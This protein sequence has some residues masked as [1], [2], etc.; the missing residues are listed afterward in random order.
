MT[1]ISG[2]AGNGKSLPV[3]A[4]LRL[5]APHNSYRIAF[6]ARPTAR[7]IREGNRWRIDQHTTPISTSTDATNFTQVTAGNWASGRASKAAGWPARNVGFVRIRVNAATGGYVTIGGVRIGGRTDEPALVSTTLPGD[8]PVYRLVA[9][10]SGKVADV[11]GGPPPTTPT[12]TDVLQWPW[13]NK[14][15]Q[16]W[17]FPRTDDCYHEIKGVGSGKLMEVAGLSRADGG[18][19]GI[20]SAPAPPSS[21]GPSPPPVTAP[22]SSSTATAGPASPSTRAAPPTEPMSSNS[23]TR[24]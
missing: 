17:T 16:K 21:T 7:D 15:N 6:R 4:S 12:N 13:L 11:K 3:N 22:T 10:H 24:H 5:L 19:V 18:D 2:A 9:R 23:R 20:W 1:C 8:G 14:A